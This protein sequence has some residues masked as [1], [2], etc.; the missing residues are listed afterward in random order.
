MKVVDSSC[1]QVPRLSCTLVNIITIGRKAA[2][3]WW[4]SGPGWCRICVLTIPVCQDSCLFPLSFLKRCVGKA[5]NS[6]PVI[7]PK[8]PGCSGQG[9]G[10][11]RW[12]GEEVLGRTGMEAAEGMFDR[13]GRNDFWGFPRTRPLCLQ[14]GRRAVSRWFRWGEKGG[15]VWVRPRHCPCRRPE[16]C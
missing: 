12:P 6:R 4:H 8:H 7:P 15:H 11:C 1:R 5:E 2:S 10:G 14:V 9:G 13:E 3:S 16:L